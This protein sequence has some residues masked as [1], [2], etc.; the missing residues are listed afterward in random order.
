MT[1]CEILLYGGA[2]VDYYGRSANLKSGYQV[3]VRDLEVIPVEQFTQDDV[4]RIRKQANKRGGLYA[5]F[6][7]NDGK[8]YCD[9]SKRIPTKQAAL[10]LGR[11]LNQIS[12][13]NWRKHECI[14]C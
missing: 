1:Q 5:G 9:L 3:S 6:W 10:Q 4:Q 2:T 11:Q 7:V 8:V 13:F 14:Y 12:I